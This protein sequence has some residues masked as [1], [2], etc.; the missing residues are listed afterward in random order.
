MFIVLLSLSAFRAVFISLLEFHLSSLQCQWLLHHE[1]EPKCLFC[2]NDAIL[3]SYLYKYTLVTLNKCRV[4]IYTDSSIKTRQISLK[5]ML[6]D[7]LKNSY[8]AKQTSI[9]ETLRILPRYF[10][11]HLVNF[12]YLSRSIYK[13][14]HCLTMQDD[15]SERF[16]WYNCYIKLN[17]IPHWGAYCIK[18]LK[19]S[20][21]KS[22]VFIRLSLFKLGSMKCNLDGSLEETKQKKQE[23]FTYLLE[24]NS[25]R[26]LESHLHN[27][28]EQL[29]TV[30][31]IT[32][33]R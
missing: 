2:N 25:Q 3:K 5:S 27:C 4:Y 30:E 29:E 17:K 1:K 10:K 24:V 22:V 7:Y 28:W 13:T 6:K 11:I 9:Q 19:L 20:W 16:H 14:K 18:Y 15:A 33:A 26:F 8:D 23:L 21:E 31:E 12:S 32:S